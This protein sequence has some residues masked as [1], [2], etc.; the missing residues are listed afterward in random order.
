MNIFW[1]NFINRKNIW[2]Y[3]IDK[4]ELPFNMLKVKFGILIYK[5]D[6]LGSGILIIME[7]HPNSEKKISRFIRDYNPLS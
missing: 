7:W 1:H 6:G 2:T 5:E 4:F 3:K